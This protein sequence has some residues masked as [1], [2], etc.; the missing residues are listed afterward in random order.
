[1]RTAFRNH[2]CFVVLFHLFLVAGWFGL[3]PPGRKKS[4]LLEQHFA[5]R[6]SDV[7][8][9]AAKGNCV[10][11]TC[12]KLGRFGPSIKLWHLV[13]PK[14][15]TRDY[16]ELPD[17]DTK[18]GRGCGLEEHYGATLSHRELCYVKVFLIMQAVWATGLTAIVQAGSSQL[19]KKNSQCSYPSQHILSHAERNFSFM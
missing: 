12:A 10:A 11:Q 2:L 13:L 7:L 1:M 3:E 5:E 17:C 16:V 19:K 15:N 6:I 14:R 18:G 8:K 9:V 4:L